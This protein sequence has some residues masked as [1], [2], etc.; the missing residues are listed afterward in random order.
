VIIMGKKPRLGLYYEN[1]LIRKRIE[2]ASARRGISTTAYCTKAVEEC[3]VRDGELGTP[4]ERKQFI[5]EMDKQREGL[6]PLGIPTTE[7]TRDPKRRYSEQ[8][9]GAPRRGN[10]QDKKQ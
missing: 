4:E 1:E 5:E 8:L 10:T 3:L 7:V 9:R 2:Y 6:G